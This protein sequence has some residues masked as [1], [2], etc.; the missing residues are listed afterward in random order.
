MSAGFIA[1]AVAT[2]NFGAG[3]F[4]SKRNEGAAGISKAQT[5]KTPP[6]NSQRSGDEYTG[7]KAKLDFDRISAK[8]LDSN[9]DLMEALKRVENYRADFLEFV[10]TLSYYP[11]LRM[12]DGNYKC[13]LTQQLWTG[14]IAGRE[15]G[16]L[17]N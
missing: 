5:P 16:R 13:S 8:E 7:E 9:F 2:N 15:H 12:I 14:Y 6:I 4:R 10:S 1:L 11:D 3:G 17:H